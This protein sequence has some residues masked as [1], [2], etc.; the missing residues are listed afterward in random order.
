MNKICVATFYTEDIESL[1]KLISP[2]YQKYCD[3]HGYDF[4]SK[5]ISGEKYER[6][7]VWYKINFIQELLNKYDWV[8]FV[9]CDT[10]LTNSNLTIE[11]FIKDGKDFYISKDINGINAGV[12]LLKNSDWT[13]QFLKEC[14]EI[15]PNHAIYKEPGFAW[16]KTQAEQRAIIVMINKFGL[17]KVEFI[18]QKIFNAYTYNIWRL[19][20]PDGEWG[21]E[22]FILHAPG[23]S[24]NHRL[25]IFL[26]KLNE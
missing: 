8:L 24:L 23:C 19:N 18:P 9:D 25:E 14:W 20:Y 21:P 2:S 3:M 7:P 10:L 16:D 12:I 1:Y 5:N 11:S 6:H 13:K 4:V 15:D 17:E 26:S 22:S